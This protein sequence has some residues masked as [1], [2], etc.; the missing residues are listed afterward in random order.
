MTIK[1]VYLSTGE[2]IISDVK[3]LLHEKQLRGYLLKN[4][5]K[6]EKISNIFLAEEENI[7]GDHTTDEMSITISPWIEFSE[8]ME[9]PITPYVVVAIVNPI[10]TLKEIYLEKINEK[11]SVPCTE[12]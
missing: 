4:P 11:N 5:V 8:D 6:I 2:K 9:I 12:E 10:D 7:Y 3:E 1:V